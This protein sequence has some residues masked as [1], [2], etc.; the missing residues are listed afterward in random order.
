MKRVVVGG[1]CTDSEQLEIECK[2]PFDFP[3]RRHIFRQI[4]VGVVGLHLGVGVADTIEEDV[5]LE[6]GV[7]KYALHIKGGVTEILWVPD[8]TIAD[9]VGVAKV[10]VGADLGIEAVFFEA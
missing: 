2:S 3:G 5:V 1:L 10:V 4:V 8:D 9:L 6:A 7:V